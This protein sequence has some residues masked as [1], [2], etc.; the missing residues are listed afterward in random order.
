MGQR[1]SYSVTSDPMSFHNP[2]KALEHMAGVPKPAPEAPKPEPPPAPAKGPSFPRAVVRMER[3]GRG[4]KTVTIVEH[5][6]IKPADRESWV[7][8]LKSALG[9][10]GSVEDDTL[11]F[12]GD[13]RKRLPALLTGRGVKKVTIG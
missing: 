11:V 5:L 7:K 12:Q 6:E 3:S 9:C 10:G 1:I 8:A 13:H 2:F 4:G